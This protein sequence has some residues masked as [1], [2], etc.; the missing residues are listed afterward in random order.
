MSPSKKERISSLL[1]K[2]TAYCDFY[3]INRPVSD[4]PS[5]VEEGSNEAGEAGK[6][7]FLKAVSKEL[8]VR[9]REM[10]SA[11]EQDLVVG[12]M[13][14]KGVLPVDLPKTVSL[15]AV[16]K[17]MKKG[18]ISTTDDLNLARQFI[19]PDRV[20]QLGSDEAAIL[21]TMLDKIEAKTG[22][23]NKAQCF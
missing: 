8:D 14:G 13:I 5:G 7:T 17:L 2:I 4:F 9:I 1:S 20:G 22:Q 12:L 11:S 15:S 21:G 3:R 10:L 18:F 16:K 23:L 6:I 19:Q